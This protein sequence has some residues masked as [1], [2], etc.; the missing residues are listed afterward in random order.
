MFKLKSSI[1]AIN[2]E[3]EQRVANIRNAIVYNMFVIG[4]KCVNEARDNHL[5]LNQ[6]GNLCSSIG[7][8]VID[9]G[10]IVHEGSWHTIKDGQEGTSTGTEYLHKIAAEVAAPDKIVLVLVAGMEYAS[11]VEDMGLNVLDSAEKL[12]QRELKKFVD[13]F[14]TTK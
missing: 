10:Q 2:E 6:T 12:M 3:I 4:E 13:K 9:N 1:Q 7:Y 11:Y 14:L 8:C 5:Y